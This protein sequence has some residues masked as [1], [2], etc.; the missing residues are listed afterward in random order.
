MKKI[1]SIALII[2]ILL[3]LFGCKP[4]SPEEDVVLN[5]EKNEKTVAADSITDEDGSVEDRQENISTNEDVEQSF[6]ETDGKSSEDSIP[7]SSEVTEVQEP[8]QPVTDEQ[9]N[10]NVDANISD[11][12]TDSEDYCMAEME[13]SSVEEL[14]TSLKE[15]KYPDMVYF[16]QNKADLIDYFYAPVAE[17][18]GYELQNVML[19]PWYVTFRYVPQEELGK[20]FDWLDNDHI[21]YYY[22]R[23]D[24]AVAFDM[25]AELKK[26]ADKRGEI[27]DDGVWYN[28]ERSEISFLVDKSMVHFTFPD[29]MND[30]ETLKPLLEMEKITIK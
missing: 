9:I 29:S 11:E 21:F 19:G 27:I 7:D 16:E 13:F 28:S 2:L 3:S 1:L 6:E 14:V 23:N 10:N 5:D 17:I 8:E 24:R 20:E 25:E 22:T 15:K 12:S 18:P 30:Y 4:K 26:F